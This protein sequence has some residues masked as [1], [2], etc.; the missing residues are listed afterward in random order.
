VLR[1]ASWVWTLIQRWRPKSS[2]NF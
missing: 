2:K 1:C